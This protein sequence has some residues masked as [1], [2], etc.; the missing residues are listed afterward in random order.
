MAKSGSGGGPNSR[1][2]KNSNAGRKVEPRSQGI[3]PGHVAQ[4]GTAL[5]SHATGQGKPL[6]KAVIPAKTPGYNPPVGAN[7]NAKPTA[8]KSG[9]QGQHGPVAGKPAPQGRDIL[10]GFGPD[11]P[12]RR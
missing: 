9:T 8:M 5:G 1:V 10:G 4:I 6:T 7:V 3:R 11:I 12:G 2:V